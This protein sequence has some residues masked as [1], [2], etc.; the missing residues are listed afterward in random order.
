MKEVIEPND[1]RLRLEKTYVHDAFGNITDSKETAWNGAGAPRP[2]QTRKKHTDYSPD[3]RFI[4]STRNDLGHVELTEH[5]PL[6]GQVFHQTGPNKIETRWEFDGFGRPTHEMRAD[7]SETRSWYRRATPG[8]GGAPARAVH[9]VITQSSANPAQTIWY[10]ILDREIQRDAVGFDGTPI[11]V[12]KVFNERGETA[13]MSNPFFAGH[14][15]V[16]ATMLYDAIGREVS[17]TLPGNR[18]STMSYHGLTTTV[19]NSENQT[20][21]R[22]AT[23]LDKLAGALDASQHA[24]TYQHDAAG[25]LAGVTDDA[26]HTTSITY[27]NRG[28]K[29]AMIEPNTGKTKYEYNGFG[30]L[31][32]QTTSDGLRTTFTYDTLGRPIERVEPDGTSRWFY[33]N[34][35]DPVD[36]FAAH[37]IGKLIRVKKGDFRK[38]HRYDSFGRPVE[39]ITRINTVSFSTTTSYDYVGRTDTITYPTTFAIRNVYNSFGH[40]AEVRNAASGNPFWTARQV[41][42]RG[43][44]EREELGNGLATD[45]TFNPDTGWVEAIQTGAASGSLHDTQNLAYGFNFLGN[46]TNRRDVARGITETFAL[47]E[48]NRLTDV[49][50]IGATADF[51]HVQ[52]TYDDLGNPTAR[53]DAGTYTYSASGPHAVTGLTQR[54]DGAPDLRYAYDPRGNRKRTDHAIAGGWVNDLRIAYTA[55]N[56]PS[57]IVGPRSTATFSY[58]P[59]R[60]RYRQVEQ[61]KGGTVLKRF[62]IGG[63]YEK[64]RRGTTTRHIHYIPGGSGVVAI[65]QTEEG[66]SSFGGERTLYVHKDHLGSVESLTDQNRTLVEHMNYDAWG[67]RRTLT[68]NGGTFALAYTPATPLPAANVSRGFTGHEMLDAFGLVHMN[69][70]LYDPLTGRF[71]SADPIVQELDNLQNLNRYSYVLNN[72]LSLTDPSGFSFIGKY[73]K[74][75]IA[76]VVAI[77]VT[78][79]APYL[80]PTLSS[81]WSTVAVGRGTVAAA[82]ARIQGI[83]HSHIDRPADLDRHWRLTA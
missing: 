22:T 23:L 14:A 30:E 35:S 58:A 50:L 21:T 16:Y 63:L 61:Y 6:L 68:L 29:T 82:R 60:S 59:D 72:P 39:T 65:Q 80:L 78:I 13:A 32:A 25:N 57:L 83:S 46:L 41:N 5:E 33:D 43:Q 74:Q 52:A 45:R 26:N 2:N 56:L 70:R 49:T 31:I 75:A 17:Q 53:T 48:L 36:Q 8:Q 24:L 7:G 76:A 51:A 66:P 79:Y 55:A 37:S 62:Y 3:G 64:E 71:L 47:D 1:P 42:A 27:D 81:F 15:P 54:P 19:T 10:D 20:H 4:T 18:V 69:G 44:V 11:S 9:C 12:R 73:W 40:L 34:Y 77:V 28:N 38:D 67:R